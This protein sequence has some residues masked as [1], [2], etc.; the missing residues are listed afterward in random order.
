MPVIPQH[1]EDKVG[2]IHGSVWPA[3]AAMDLADKKVE[4]LGLRDEFQYLVQNLTAKGQEK[5][6]W[7]A[8]SS[9]QLQIAQVA[10]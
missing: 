4:G 9:A 7:F 10:D 3:E 8:V 6:K 1:P 2:R 5:H